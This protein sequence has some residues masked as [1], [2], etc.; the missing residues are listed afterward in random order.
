[1][2]AS[3]Q[4]TRHTA[5]LVTLTFVTSGGDVLLVRHPEANDRFPGRWNGIG[6]HVETGECIRGAARRELREETGLDVSDISLR[7]VVHEAGLLGHDHVLFVF[8]AGVAR[9]PVRSPEGLELAWHPIRALAAL[10]LVD[11]V[12]DLLSRA[13]AEPEPFFTTATFDGG[14]RR[15]PTASS[16]GAGAR[17]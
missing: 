3:E 8:V 14:D 10:P 9:R 16:L 12:P 15:A 4:R 6:G 17:A 1:M 11:D 13:L 5:R 2:G 7:G